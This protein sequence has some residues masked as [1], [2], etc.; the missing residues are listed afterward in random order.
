M[1]RELN[2]KAT[3]QKHGTPLLR[4]KR[5]AFT[6]TEVVVASSL[7]ILAIVP[8]LKALTSVHVTSSI[9]ERKTR[10]LTLA[11][12]KLNDIKARTIYG[13]TSSYTENDTVLESS[14]LCDVTDTG[15]GSDIR[16]IAVSVGFDLDG[17][18]N[19]DA[20]ETSVTLS[21][22]LANRWTD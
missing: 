22:Y 14:Y 2:K 4:K 20:D 11:Q 18:G 16:T 15:S 21:T 5:S 3:T 1:R 9:I 8:I 6:I 17:N 10:G 12:G 19:L 7:L 13:Y